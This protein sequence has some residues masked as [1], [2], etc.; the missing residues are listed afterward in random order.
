MT[1]SHVTFLTPQVNLYMSELSEFDETAKVQRPYNL[2]SWYLIAIIIFYAIP[3]YQLVGT[4][5]HV[6]YMISY[7]II[8]TSFLLMQ[9]LIVSGNNDLCYYNSLCSHPVRNNMFTISAFNNVFSNIG[10]FVL[11]VLFILIAYRR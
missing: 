6:C 5:Q 4:Y 8:M 9:L 2:L 11:G 3:A 7:D 10:Y 1:H